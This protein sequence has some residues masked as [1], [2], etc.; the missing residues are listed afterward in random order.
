[1][2]FEIVANYNAAIIKIFKTLLCVSVSMGRKLENWWTLNDSYWAYNRYIMLWFL[3]IFFYTLH[4]FLAL[5][6]I[7]IYL[8]LWLHFLKPVHEGRTSVVI[9]SFMKESD[10]HFIYG[11][12]INGTHQIVVLCELLRSPPHTNL[13]LAFRLSK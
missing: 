5:F 2:T 6:Q 3:E 8:F 7:F 4:Y 10:S 1:M 9:R 13:G 12:V 11:W